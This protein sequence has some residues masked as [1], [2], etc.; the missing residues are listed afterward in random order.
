MPWGKEFSE[1]ATPGKCRDSLALPLFTHNVSS[2]DLT[3]LDSNATTQPAP[4]VIAKMMQCLTDGWG[5]PSSAHRFGQEARRSIDEAR[6]NVAA[7]VNCTDREL[8]F[9]SGGSEAINTSIRGLLLARTPRRKIITSATEHSATKESSG[10]YARE[11]YEVVEIGVDHS[12]Q[13]DMDAYLAALDDNTAL[14]TM[15]WANNETGTIF[16]MEKI[17][18][19]AKAKKIP[20]H[21]DLTQCLGKIPVDLAAMPIDCA[22]FA[23]HKFHGPKGVGALYTRKGMR[24]R[25]LVMGGPQENSK[26]GG[27][28]NVP[29]IVGMG[30][31][32]RLAKVGLPEM[33]GRVMRLRDRLEANILERVADTRVNGDRDHRLPNTT[34]ISFARLASEPILLLLSEHGVCAS[35]GSACS[36]GSLEPS[37]VIRAMGIEE[38]WTGA[39]RFSLSRYTTDAEVDRCIAV[40]PGLIEKLRKVMP[41]NA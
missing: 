18:A 39:I 41:V 16:P 2:M 8:T 36:S 40:L 9:M 1:D 32:A 24:L 22:S 3:Y 20:I 23:A 10:Q 33:S 11:G 15:L 6:A 14:V 37:H 28:E 7:L 34:N 30:E 25:S 12:G 17:A 19:A 26:R 38:T 31:A 27:T 29:G 5:N 13:L 21:V 4:E 35:A